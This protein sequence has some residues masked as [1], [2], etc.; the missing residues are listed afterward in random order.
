M[1]SVW[2]VTRDGA[3]GRKYHLYFTDPVSGKNVHHKG[4]ER[5]KDAQAEGHRLR[6]YIDTGSLGE[7]RQAKERNRPLTVGDVAEALAADWETRA[8]KGRLSPK[9]L[10]GYKD[11]LSLVVRDF[12]DRLIME[13]SAEEV[14]AYHIALL[15][16]R[17]PV[18]ANRRLFVLKQVGKK[19]AALKAVA[20]N[21]YAAITYASEAKQ[22]RTRRLSPEEAAR[23][24]RAAADKGVRRYMLPIVLLTL[25]YGASRQE[26]LD[27]SWDRV[28][29][30]EGVITFIRTKNGVV[31]TRDLTERCLAALADWKKQ[32]RG[33][34]E[35]RNVTRPSSNL[36]FCHSDGRRF[37]DFRSAWRG[38]TR[39]AALVDYRFHDNRHT[40]CSSIVNVGGS[41]KDV[42]EMIGHRD[43]RSAN[44][45]SHLER[46]RVAD[47][48]RRVGELYA[49]VGE[50]DGDE[51]CGKRG[52]RKGAGARGSRGRG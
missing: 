12:G 24:V 17:T 50:S 52:R 45:Y 6:A 15:K 21:P 29:L 26:L 32:Q 25:D 16:K 10:Q 49:R 51:G 7:L 3:R 2:I 37:S 47:V 19:A 31:R 41:L 36:V 46:E 38:L 18:T 34:R 48:Q 8:V 1:A 28:D 14:E 23:L 43:I 39:A 4:F 22:M 35:R 44:R 27:L 13:L 20:G 33:Q 5:W 40:Y 11:F 9:T 30:A 42:M